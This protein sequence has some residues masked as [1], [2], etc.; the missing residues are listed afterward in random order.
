MQ[1]LQKSA[2]WHAPTWQTEYHLMLSKRLGLWVRGDATRQTKRETCT[3]G[4][5]KSMG[6]GLRPTRS[7]C[8]SQF[9]E[10]GNAEKHVYEFSCFKEMILVS[11]PRGIQYHEKRNL[12]YIGQYVNSTWDG[13]DGSFVFMLHMCWSRFLKKKIQCHFKYHFFFHMKSFTN[14]T[15]PVLCRMGVWKTCFLFK[16]V[17]SFK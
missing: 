15:G 9:L 17:S 6:L 2:T 11:E 13:M 10:R 3:G 14:F 8:I 1:T 12:E 5:I 7:P 16:C 4:F